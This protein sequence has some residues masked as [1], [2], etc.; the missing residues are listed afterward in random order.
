VDLGLLAVLKSSHNHLRALGSG[1]KIYIQE[2]VRVRQNLRWNWI[3]ILRTVFNASESEQ[4]KGYGYLKMS[5][6][7]Y[8]YLLSK[9]FLFSFH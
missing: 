5:R 8:Q 3:M 2:Y 1:W 7:I 4:A 6:V 9:N